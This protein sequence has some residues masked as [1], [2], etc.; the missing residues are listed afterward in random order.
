M[1]VYELSELTMVQ[2]SNFL[3]AFSVFLSVVTAYIVAAYVVG[4]KLT[5]LQLAIVNCCFLIAATILGYL[6]SASFRVF[7]I[8]ASSNSEGPVAQSDIGPVLVD[9]T[10]PLATLLFVIEIGCFV[11]MYSVRRRGSRI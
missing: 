6:T 5:P 4:S 3:T 11:F 2:M 9:F 8:W 1:S 7:F 10:W